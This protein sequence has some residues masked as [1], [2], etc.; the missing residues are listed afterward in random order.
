MI[1]LIR[2]DIFPILIKFLMAKSTRGKID[3][4]SRT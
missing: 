3:R 4:W 1:Y 2:Y